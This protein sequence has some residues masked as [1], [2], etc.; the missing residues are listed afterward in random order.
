MKEYKVLAQSDS[1]WR[2]RFSPLALQEA[3]NEHARK[4]WRVVTCTSTEFTG[5][6]G[7][8]SKRH[9]LF[10][11]L[12][13]DAIDTS[14]DALP[15]VESAATSEDYDSS[16]IPA[17]RFYANVGNV[18]SGLQQQGLVTKDQMNRAREEMAKRGGHLCD[19]LLALGFLDEPA[20]RAF[21][22]KS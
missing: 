22:G 11:L 16:R 5:L 9:E 15:R 19:H 21:L 7:L 6:G 20:L 12:E 10:I 2:D 18:S 14:A 1:F 8:G 4:G 13:R 17:N 3:L